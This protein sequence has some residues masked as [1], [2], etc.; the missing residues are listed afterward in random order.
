MGPTEPADGAASLRGA[1]LAVVGQ[2]DAAQV[3]APPAP[4]HL[5][6]ARALPAVVGQGEVAI[7]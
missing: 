1:L 3:Q 6:E 7:H 4:V 2:G 5:P